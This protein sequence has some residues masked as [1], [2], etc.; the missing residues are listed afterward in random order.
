MANYSNFIG[1]AWSAHVLTAI[2]ENTFLRDFC[3]KEYEGEVKYNKTI[4]IN[5]VD[6]PTIGDYT[7]ASIGAPT[8]PN[9]KRVTMVIDKAKYFNVMVDDVEKVQMKPE[10]MKALTKEAGIALASTA[11]RIIAKEIADSSATAVTTAKPVKAVAATIATVDDL[12]KAIDDAFLV[13]YGNNVPLNTELELV[14][15]P[16][17]YQMFRTKI[18][19]LSTDNVEYIKKGI[20]GRY[21][22]ALVKMSNLLSTDTASPNAVNCFLRTNKAV[23]YAEQ[24]DSLEAF[25]PEGFFSDAIKGLHVYGTKVVRPEEIAVIK[26]S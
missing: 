14:L 3:T 26:L 24:I 8:K 17:F 2:A 7:G 5:G 19:E 20:V 25:R 9:D 4:H 12:Q 21:N 6:R 13:L 22:N 16:K 1:E 10:L 15:S 18:T 23:A 11:D